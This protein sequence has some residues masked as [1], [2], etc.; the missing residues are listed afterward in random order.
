ME[1][2]IVCAIGKKLLDARI[3]QVWPN[4]L[5]QNSMCLQMTVSRGGSGKRVLPCHHWSDQ[6]SV[7]TT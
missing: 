7:D 3:D 5:T 4:H 2:W 1:M 6:S